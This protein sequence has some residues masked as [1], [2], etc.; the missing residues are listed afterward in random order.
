MEN[1]IDSDSNSGIAA[2]KNKLALENLK[3][4]MQDEEEDTSDEEEDQDVDELLEKDKSKS[5]SSIKM[6]KK[7]DL[8]TKLY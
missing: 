5:Q 1:T 2:E 8:H 4:N 3:K 6:I 7:T